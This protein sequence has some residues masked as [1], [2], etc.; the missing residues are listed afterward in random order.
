MRID[1]KSDSKGI[2]ESQISFLKSQMLALGK[3]YKH[4]ADFEAIWRGFAYEKGADG[5]YQRVLRSITRLQK[6][7]ESLKADLKDLDVELTKDLLRDV[8]DSVTNKSLT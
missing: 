5:Q 3:E 6:L 8:L 2:T 7:K 1:V 4:A